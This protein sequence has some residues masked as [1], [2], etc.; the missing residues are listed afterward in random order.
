MDGMDGMEEILCRKIFPVQDLFMYA[1]RTD[2]IVL[3]FFSL[4]KYIKCTNSI[5]TLLKP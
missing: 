1:A 3:D 4:T 5:S 2:K